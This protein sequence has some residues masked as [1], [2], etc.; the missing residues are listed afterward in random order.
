[1]LKPTRRAFLSGVALAAAGALSGCG[2]D[3]PSNGF[4]EFRSGANLRS[5]AVGSIR[6]FI[7]GSERGSMNAGESRTFP[8]DPGSHS[9]EARDVTGSWGPSTFSPR[10]GET[11]VFTLN[12]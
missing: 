1:M 3:G 11:A 7:D 9:V 6:L 10:A 8:V 4:I 2:D 5:C 12:C